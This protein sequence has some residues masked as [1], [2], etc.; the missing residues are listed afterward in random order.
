MTTL[1]HLS[2]KFHFIKIQEQSFITAGFSFQIEEIDLLPQFLYTEYKWLIDFSFCAAVINVLVEIFA[3]FLPEI[4]TQ[5]L[6]L[7]LVWNFLVIV[8]AV[9]PLL[10]GCKE[11]LRNT[12]SGVYIFCCLYL[13]STITRTHTIRV[14]SNLPRVSIVMPCDFRVWAPFCCGWHTWPR[15]HTTSLDIALPSR[16][17]PRREN[18]DR[19]HL[20]NL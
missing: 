15:S 20:P 16:N 6:N 3:F 5:E 18:T 17:H 19:T 4:Y 14:V 11:V 12:R 1:L 9:Y 10:S 7:G 13:R 2:G 8:F